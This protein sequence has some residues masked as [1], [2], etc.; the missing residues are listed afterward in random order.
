MS[1]EV[2][3]WLLNGPVWI[4]YAVELQLLDLKP[5]VPPVIEDVLILKT[6]HRLTKG[7]TGFPALGTSRTSYTDTGNFFWDLFFLA[8]IGLAAEKLGLEQEIEK[9]LNLQLSNG[10]FIPDKRTQPNYFCMS[11]ILISAVAK[12]GYRDDARI[13]KYI[14]LLLSSRQPDGGW[15]CFED[16]A[17][18]SCV[19]DN[20][21]VLM[22]LGQ[23]DEYKDDSSLHGAIN[24]LLEHWDRRFE[25]WKPDGF[26]TGKR[27]TSLYYP[28]VKYSILRVLDVLS[29]FPY[30]TESKSFHSM[31]DFVR[32]KAVSGKYYAEVTDP[33]YADFDF[34]QT[35]EPSRWLTFLI[36]RVEKRAENRQ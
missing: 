22:L 18:T 20:Q 1:K 32:Q 7:Q 10:A 27:F 14:Q 21:N 23:Y 36:S 29:L 19:M 6:L 11:A 31:L 15:H 33:A 17:S 13:K 28:A 35:K 8:D 3:E 9:V 30:A 34:G 2:I 4:K 26:G 12:M 25:S 16:Y 5:D 24:L